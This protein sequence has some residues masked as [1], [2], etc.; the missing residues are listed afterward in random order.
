LRFDIRTPFQYNRCIKKH[1][2]TSR[3]Q[4]GGY[5]VY[6]TKYDHLAAPLWLLFGGRDLLAGKAMAL[7]REIDAKG[8]ISNAA[9]AV[10]MSYKTA[11]DLVDK[12][13][14][15]SARP[16]VETTTGGRHGGGTRLSEYGRSLLS[17]YTSLKR[18][19]EAMAQSYTDPLPDMNGFLRFMKGL[20]M[21]TSARNQLA[22]TVTGVRTGMVNTEVRITVGKDTAIVSTVTNE[23]ASNLG[24]TAG[25]DVVALIKA[26]SVIL[27][28]G[29]GPV[30]TSAENMLRGSVASVAVGR[31]NG[32]VVIE[33]P[34]GKTV[35]AIVTGESV[36]SMGIREGEPVCAAFGA[37]QVILAL[38]V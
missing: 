13:N 17:I 29:T 8:S 14:N 4:E 22:G 20:C 36:K 23:S 11:W 35:T 26:S 34:G 31:V 33:L 18:S 28:P 6:G 16:I 19:Y 2:S 27:F 25:A 30:A 1:T 24:L 10:P 37:S 21:K 9:K 7:M 38:P 5:A 12:L 32:E 3:C 15:A